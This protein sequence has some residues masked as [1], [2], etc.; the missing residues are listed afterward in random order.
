MNRI[1]Q[2]VNTLT[3][4]LTQ[5][6]GSQK[7]ATKK[8]LA[9]KATKITFIRA[10]AE[11]TSKLTLQKLGELDGITPQAVGARF[12]KAG[13]PWVPFK[14]IYN[15]GGQA[16]YD[17]LMKSAK[18][19]D[20]LPMIKEK[21]SKMGL[22]LTDTQIDHIARYGLGTENKPSNESTGTPQIPRIHNRKIGKTAEGG[23]NKRTGEAGRLDTSAYNS[24][25]AHMN[26]V[27]GLGEAEVERIYGSGGFNYLGL[28]THKFMSAHW[29]E[30][31][32]NHDHS[33]VEIKLGNDPS[34]VEL[35]SKV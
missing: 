20:R 14:I 13:I 2:R 16:N 6:E 33:K 30:N 11:D 8:T 5:V 31:I 34:V 24:G 35:T 1:V 3:T 15:L 21:L 12:K 17:L 22:N 19:G 7:H 26:M 23:Y 25:Q 18:D 9:E 27:T 28:K 29:H 4:A 32:N 10:A